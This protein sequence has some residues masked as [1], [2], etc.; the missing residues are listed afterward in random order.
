VPVPVI[1]VPYNP[2]WPEFY[3]QEK[4][5]VVKVMGEKVKSIEHIGSSSVP[6]LGGKDIVDFAVGVQSRETADESVDLLQA[7]DYT[8]ITPQPGHTQWFY[9]LGK[10]PGLLP[11]YHLH[12]MKCPSPFWTKH[13][14][15]RY[16]LRKHPEVALEY[17]N[18][19]KRLAEKY[20][21]DRIGYT[22]AK[23]IFIERVMN[24]E[25]KDLL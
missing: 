4:E 18:L 7:L 16:Y 19:K 9:C 3:K 1:I 10:S 24:K 20:G 13:I 14:L 21:R 5:K 25:R 11:R 2:R 8:S 12:L 17:F 15:F 6:G 22:E 23:T